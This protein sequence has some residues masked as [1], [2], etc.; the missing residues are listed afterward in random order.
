MPGGQNQT[1]EAATERL[2][3]PRGEEIFCDTCWRKRYVLRAITV[4]VVS[5]VDP[6]ARC[7]MVNSR[8]LRRR[9]GLVVESARSAPGVILPS[10]PKTLCSL[11][12]PM[13]SLS[14][15]VD[16]QMEAKGG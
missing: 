3:A 15:V 5:P 16:E 6:L 14:V 13:C 4:P 10:R 11:L 8:R 12:P 9:G 2:E 1:G 7:S